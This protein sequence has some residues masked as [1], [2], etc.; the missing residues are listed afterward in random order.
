MEF[1]DYEM[2]RM[3]WWVLLGVVLIGF[4]ASDGFD[5]GVTALLPFVAKTDTERRVAI[6]TV[7]PVWEGNQVWLLLGGGAIFAAW[8][9][10]YAVSFSGFYLAMFIIL[11]AL[12]IRPVA[13]KFRSKRPEQS[14][15]NRWDWAL[16]IGGFVPA[17][18]TGVAVGNALLGVPFHFSKLMQITYDGN[19]FGLLNPFALLCGLVSL[20][21]IILHGASWL[22]LKT[23]GAIAERAKKYG[24]IS[25]LIVLV[26]FAVGGVLIANVIEG[27]VITSALDP[28]G[29]SNPTGKTVIT[30]V[31]AWM[32]NYSEHQ[33]MLVAP[34]LGFAGTALAMLFLKAGKGGFS[35]V[36]SKLGIFGIIS[37]VGLSM[38]PMILPSSA[39]PSQSLTVFDSSS[40]HGTLGIMLVVTLTLLPIVLV[41][42]S[43]AYKV[44]WGKVEPEYV[45][46]S[47]DAY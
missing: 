25:G 9:I 15:R 14:W 31:G 33:W 24:L 13:F 20:G 37:T 36:C 26:L 42:T 1:F 39:E 19:L 23:D 27:Y 32:N 29:P 2:L 16:F 47:Q 11:F 45:E 3:I 28:N 44:M 17:L 18:I 38:F 5:M 43:W 8:P 10:L 12:I 41:Y 30:E 4:A 22:V 21:M 46:N 35:F 6:N 34:I 7:A 40:S